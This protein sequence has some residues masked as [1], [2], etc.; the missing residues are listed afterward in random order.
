VY[1]YTGEGKTG[2]QVMM[3]SNRAIAE[4]DVEGYALRLFIAVGCQPGSGTR[5]HQYVGQFRVDPEL[6]YFTVSCFPRL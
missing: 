3:R 2:D 6:P 5:I 1:Y 4:H